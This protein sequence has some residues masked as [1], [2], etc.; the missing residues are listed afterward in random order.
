L[1]KKIEKLVHLVGFITGI[2]TLRLIV[3]IKRRVEALA[4][5]LL[6]R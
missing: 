1:E 3:G 6:L 2:K 4:L 5:R